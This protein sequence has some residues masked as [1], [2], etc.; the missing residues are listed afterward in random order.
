MRRI[1]FLITSLLL[2][3]FAT[4]A[5]QEITFATDLMPEQGNRKVDLVSSLVYYVT[6]TLQNEYQIS[7]QQ[8]SREREWRLVTKQNNVCLYNKTRTPE[9]EKIAVFSSLPLIV[10]AP[11]RLIL[12]RNLDLPQPLSLT[13]IIS[14]GLNIGVVKGRNYGEQL[15]L[16]IAKHSEHLYVGAGSYK[17]ERL[18]VMLKQG[19]LDGIIE[20]SSVFKSRQPEAVIN[21]DYY[22][23]ALKEAQQ[24]VKGFL[25]CSDSNVGKQFIDDFE[26]V[27]LSEDYRTFAIS[28]FNEAQNYIES[29]YIIEQLG[30]K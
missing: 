6:D 15:D 14:L 11:N 23:Y 1:S 22:V 18:E 2:L 13:E 29:A 24:A 16:L 28:K 25:A 3:S 26:Q 19:K 20:Y 5:K 17:A 9:R 27:M 10:Y 4:V 8:A 30:Y 7:F 21:K 12:N